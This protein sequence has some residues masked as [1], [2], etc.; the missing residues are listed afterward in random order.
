MTQTYRITLLPGD[1]IGPEIMAVAVDVLKAVGRQ[2]DLSFEFQE[3]LIGGAAIDATNSPLPEETLT[4]C[5][6]S[7][8]VL[9]AAI[10]GY[11]WDTLPRSQRPETG[12][13]GLNVHETMLEYFELPVAL[14]LIVLGGWATFDGIRRMRSLH[15]HTHNGIEHF[16]VGQ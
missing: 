14:M 16:H 15:R 3:A 12:L 4:T 1:G 6:N 5:R 13:L 10:G 8:A 9:L 11:K 7:D 2:F